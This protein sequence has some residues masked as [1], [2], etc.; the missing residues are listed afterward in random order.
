[1]NLVYNVVFIITALIT[2]I[3]D[4]RYQKIPF[5]VILTNY[6]TLC[7]ILNPKTLP[8]VILLLIL[9]YKDIPID[10]AYILEAILLVCFFKINIVVLIIC[11]LIFVVFSKKERISLMIPIE[12]G[13]LYII[14]ANSI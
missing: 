12:L 5:V 11:T 10:M 3:Y 14:F 7:A 4:Y 13:Y 2:I 9:A 8:S 1:M 6:I